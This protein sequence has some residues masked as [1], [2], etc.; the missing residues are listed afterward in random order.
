M[1]PT[2]IVNLTSSERKQKTEGILV[3]IMISPAQKPDF[4]SDMQSFQQPASA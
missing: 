4:M 3:C 2:D 1:T